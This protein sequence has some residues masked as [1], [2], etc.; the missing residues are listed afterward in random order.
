MFSDVTEHVTGDTC[1]DIPRTD[2]VMYYV[3]CTM[4][5]TREEGVNIPQTQ[6]DTRYQNE[7]SNRLAID[8]FFSFL[9]RFILFYY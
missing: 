1:L 7:V 8:I 6:P 3:L 2:V 9:I 4:A 5:D